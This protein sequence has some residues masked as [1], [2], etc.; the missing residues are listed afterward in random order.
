MLKF[1]YL[2]YHS[3]HWLEYFETGRSLSVYWISY[4]LDCEL[5]YMSLEGDKVVMI[6]LVRTDIKMS[7]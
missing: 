6:F 7:K 4:S 5:K 1:G 3:V 2:K